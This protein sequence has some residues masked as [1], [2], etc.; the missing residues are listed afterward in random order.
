MLAKPLHRLSFLGDCRTE[1][2]D[3]FSPDIVLC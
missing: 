2:G 3:D 1:L